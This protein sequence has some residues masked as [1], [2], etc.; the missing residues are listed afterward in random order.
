MT[1]VLEP[2]GLDIGYIWIH[3]RDCNQPWS[4]VEYL[5][6]Y[7]WWLFRYCGCDELAWLDGYALGSAAVGS[8]ENHVAAVGL[9]ALEV[10][11]YICAQVEA[12][13][14]V[15]DDVHLADALIGYEEFAAW[16]APFA[17]GEVAVDGLVH[18]ACGVVCQHDFHYYAGAVHGNACGGG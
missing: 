14:N 3:D 7:P 2:I 11:G 16:R 17:V 12:R 4:F 13:E 5:H 9:C 10:E 6:L 1:S 8:W 15:R 18:V